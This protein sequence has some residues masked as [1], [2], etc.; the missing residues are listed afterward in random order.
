MIS[1]RVNEATF[2]KF[3]CIA[4]KMLILFGSTYVCEQTFC[5]MSINKAHHRCK[6]SSQHLGSILRKTTTNLTPYFDALAKTG[7]PNTV[8]TQTEWEFIYCVSKVISLENNLK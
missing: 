5:I 7:N 3:R 4:H 6:L 1:E 8:S 2:P